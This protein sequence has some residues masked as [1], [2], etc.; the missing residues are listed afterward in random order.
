[1]FLEPGRLDS[2]CLPH[3]DE[4]IFILVQAEKNQPRSI[5]LFGCQQPDQWVL[6][7]MREVSSDHR[8]YIVS[9]I[10]KFVIK[11]LSTNIH[12]SL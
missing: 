5:S 12:A 6:E 7:K 8:N 3:G 1:M 10:I 2:A 9:G 4:S 11:P